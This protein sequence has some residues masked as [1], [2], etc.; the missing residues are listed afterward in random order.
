MKG[1]YSIWLLLFPLFFSFCDGSEY[2]VITEKNKETYTFSSKQKTTGQQSGW[3]ANDTIGISVYNS[4]TNTV[5]SNYINK[6]YRTDGDGFF[7][8]ATN[9]DKILHPLSGY[10][11]NIVAYYPYQAGALE[12]YEI[13]LSNQSSQRVIDVLYSDNAKNRMNTSEDMEFVFNHALS[14]II[15]YSNPGEGLIMGDLQGMGI[16]IDNVYDNAFLNLKDG[17]LDLS[18]DKTS[19]KMNMEESGYL[20]EAILLPGILSGVGLTIRL[21][22]GNAYRASFPEE[23]VL[24]AGVV[25]SYNIIINRTGVVLT[26]IGVVGWDVAELPETGPTTEMMY[27]I[28]DFYPN[29]TDKETAIGVVFWTKPGSDGKEGKIVSFDSEERVWSTLFPF[30]FQ[31]SITNGRLNTAIIVSVASSL[32]PSLDQFPAVQWCTQK[33]REWYLPSRYELHVLQELWFSNME[34]MNNNILL[35]GGD[36]FTIQDVYLSSSESRDSPATMAETY[37]FADKSWPS[38]NKT[39]LSKVRAVKVF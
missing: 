2:D 16:T 18:G 20:S 19:I 9:D 13:N 12:K 28:G 27:K 25:Y 21:A 6:K 1:M 5:Y 17:G 30:A 15:I 29:P 26:P 38:I 14:K 4:G 35:V 3:F 36:V 11:V 24:D 8:P 33:G 39:A 32:D 7:T 37:S 31:T 22:N 10:K 23:Q 34:Y